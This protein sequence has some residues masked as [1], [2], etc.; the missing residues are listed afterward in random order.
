MSWSHPH[1]GRFYLVIAVGL[2]GLLLLAV[3]LAPARGAR[4]KGLLALRASALGLLVVIL[5]NPTRV[6][7]TSQSGPVPMALFLIDESRSMSLETPVSR[8][9]AVSQLISGAEVLVPV[10]RRPPIQRYGFGRDLFVLSNAEKVEARRPETDE[11]RLTRALEQLPSRFGETLP[12]AVFVFSDG[13]S[14]DSAAL[15]STAR[16]FR[17]LGVP[18]HVAPV[19]DERISGD[20]AVQ[21]ID[22]PRDARPG[23]RVPI[24][25]TVRGRGYDG[26]RS[27][28]RIRSAAKPDGDALATLPVT[29]SGGEQAFELVIDTDRAKGPLTVE[30]SP[31]PHEAIAANNVVPLQISPRS[32]KI[33]VIYMEGGPASAFRRLSEALAEDAEI[34]CLDVGFRGFGRTSLSRKSDPSL[35]Y[36]ATRPELFGYDVVICSDIPRDCFTQDQLNWTVEFVGEHG[37]GFAMV[38]GNNSYGA[39]QYHKTVWNGLIPVDMG[40]WGLERGFSNIIYWGEG[41][42]F[43]VVVPPEAQGHP[44]WH[45]ADDPE[46]NRAILEKMPIFYGCN[47]VDRLKPAATILG[48]SDRPLLSVGQAPIF[49]CQTFGKG[50]TFAMLTDT[51][52]DWGLDFERKWGEGDNRYFRK[53]WRNVVRWLSENSGDANRRLRVETDKVFYRPGQEIQ[54]TARAF[55]EQ[56]AAT[57]AYRVVARLR[58]PTEGESQPLDATATNLVPQLGGPAYQATLTVPPASEILENQGATVHELVLDVVALDGNRVAAQSS[59]PLQVIDDPAEFRDPRPNPSLLKELAHATDGRVIETHADLAALLAGHREAAVSEV[60][61]RSPLWDTP[62]LWLLL[63]GL[64]STEWILRRLRGLA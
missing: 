11:T 3:W 51:T 56:L 17:E 7:R 12:F 63:L 47:L 23:M 46:R 1:D 27:E 14:T 35:G 49:S 13:R 32:K 38:G 64:L 10:D 25:V 15:D 16:A 22:A 52:P 62:L 20:V 42:V 26:E 33:R 21:N 30:I 18:I 60:V 48:T 41:K 2:A 55:D 39:G 34:E 50:R 61:T 37:G 57:D 5:L 43:R 45:F 29:L 53:F 4:G 6:R 54:V 9:Q 8:I 58:G 40:Q 59:A 36:P 28:L 24:R 31:L 19:G 44:I